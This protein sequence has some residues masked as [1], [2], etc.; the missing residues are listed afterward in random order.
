MYPFEL[1]TSFA[2]LLHKLRSYYVL[3][4]KSENQCLFVIYL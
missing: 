3:N 2:F 1:N 4:F